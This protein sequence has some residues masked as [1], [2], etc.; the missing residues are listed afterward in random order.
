MA[1]LWHNLLLATIAGRREFPA[2][3]SMYVLFNKRIVLS[4][5]QF[6]VYV[7]T[8]LHR[9]NNDRKKSEIKQISQQSN[10]QKGL[11]MVLFKVAALQLMYR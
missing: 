3:T 11:S 5:C 9:D 4:I 2:Q 10:I 8:F 7:F 6:T 1:R